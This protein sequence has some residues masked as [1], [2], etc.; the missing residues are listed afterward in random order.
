MAYRWTLTNLS[1]SSTEVLSKDPI[2]W[3]EGIYKITRSEKYKGAFQEYTTS[4]KFHC[5]GGGKQF[6]DNVY[7]T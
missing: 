3:D 6:I 7:Q 5:D 1:D 2:G 4:L